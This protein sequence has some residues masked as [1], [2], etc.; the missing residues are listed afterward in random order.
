L[1]PSLSVAL[2]PQNGGLPGS[3]RVI[4]L[5]TVRVPRRFQTAG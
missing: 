3:F 5:T 2:V 4:E 1:L